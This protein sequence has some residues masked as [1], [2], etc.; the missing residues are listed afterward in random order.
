MSDDDGTGD[1]MPPD[2]AFRALGDETRL[3]ILQELGAADESLSFSALRERAGSP[4][5]SRFN[6]HLGELRGH[7]VEKTDEGY[8][9]RRAG[10]SVV[11]AVLSGAVADD[12]T[13]ERTRIEEPCP[14]CG[15]PIEVR[16]EEERVEVFCT[17][18]AGLYGGG[19]GGTDRPDGYLGHLTLPQAGIRG[20]D[21]GDV[22]RT[23]QTWQMSEI[24]PAASGVCPR[25]SATL[26]RSADVCEDHNAADGLCEHCGGRHSVSHVARCTNCIYDQRGALLLALLSDTDLLAFLTSHGVNPVAPESARFSATV[27]DYDEEVHAVD[28]LDAT[29]TVE[30]DGDRL[31]V[32]VGAG[33]RVE[34]VERV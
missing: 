15:E 8:D 19:G 25:C 11:E 9:L 31:A 12:E 27:M 30:V 3:T 23:A 20:R 14:R 2:E 29:L 7:F 4:E 32:T 21:P 16:F 18:C 22:H 33:L 10:A 26:E 5:S 17:D 24:L 28:P 34:F 13:M 6:Y 1:A